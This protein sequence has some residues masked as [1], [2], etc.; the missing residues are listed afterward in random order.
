[1]IGELTLVHYGGQKKTVPIIGFD[2]AVLFIQWEGVLDVRV[3]SN[4][5]V[6]MP[7]WKVEN[8]DRMKEVH[9]LLM[10]QREKRVG[11]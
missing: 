6:G 8:H 11:K 2:S 1:M 4:K 7:S 10:G 5:I 9:R 3:R